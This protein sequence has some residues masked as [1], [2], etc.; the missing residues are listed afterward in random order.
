MRKAAART[1]SPGRPTAAPLTAGPL[2]SMEKG[3]R[4]ETAA[5]RQRGI[6]KPA[7]AGADRKIERLHGYGADTLE[8]F[9]RLRFGRKHV[10]ALDQRQ[11]ILYVQDR[12]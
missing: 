8:P 6:R 4:L 3:E 12:I 5:G 1:P 10:E 2:L 11:P 7:A 9:P